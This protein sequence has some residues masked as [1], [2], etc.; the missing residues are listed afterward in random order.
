MDPVPDSVRAAEVRATIDDLQPGLALISRAKAANRI[1]DWHRVLS[2]SDREDMQRI[3][4]GLAAL[5]SQLLGPDLDGESIGTTLAQLGRQTVAA[6]E[7]A[8]QEDL[9]VAVERL[10]YLLMHAGHALRGPRP[11]PS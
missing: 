5:K 10:G 8:A 4:K 2:A 9:G 7:H 1:D 11:I 6:S 3:A